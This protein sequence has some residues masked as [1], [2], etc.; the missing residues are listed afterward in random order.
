MPTLLADWHGNPTSRLGTVF[1][2]PWHI[3]DWAMLI[4]D[5][6]HAIV[7]FY[8][9]GMN[10]CF[11]D[12]YELDRLM[13]ESDDWGTIMR[14]FHEIRKPN[15]DAIARLAVY[16]FLEMRSKVVDP[17]F[18][19]KKKIETKLTEIFPD[20]WMTL[21]SMVTFSTIPYAEA[22]RRAGEQDALLSAIGPERLEQAL[23]EGKE[24]TERLLW[25]E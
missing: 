5:A 16:N 17:D 11:E 3:D 22:L 25:G 7:P 24:A 12:C 2:S 20:R 21:Y 15:T 8:G 4:G 14:R 19:R 1:C 18:L 10:C 13:A 9:Q 23:A 6:A